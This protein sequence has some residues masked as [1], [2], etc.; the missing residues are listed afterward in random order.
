MFEALV[1]IGPTLR[2]R[3]AEPFLQHVVQRVSVK[4]RLERVAIWC[5][6]EVPGNDNALFGELV[7]VEDL[8]DLGGLTF[9]FAVGGA[10]VVA[11]RLEVV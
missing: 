3:V 10:V 1:V 8:V 2:H 9:A 7:L 5:V 6:V 11:L 4:E